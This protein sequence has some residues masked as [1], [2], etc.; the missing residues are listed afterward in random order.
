MESSVNGLEILISRLALLFCTDERRTA[1][2][3][4]L[5]TEQWQALRTSWQMDEWN[6][7]PGKLWLISQQEQ[8]LKW[9]EKVNAE[10]A[11]TPAR[12]W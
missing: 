11:N 3:A 4:G 1:F 10:L 8:Q 5:K 2:L 12:N 7:A 6:A 9:A